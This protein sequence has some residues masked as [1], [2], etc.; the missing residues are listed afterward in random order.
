M[1]LTYAKRDDSLTPSFFF[2][3]QAVDNQRIAYLTGVSSSGKDFLLERALGEMPEA[4]RPSVL[5]MG[6][7][8]AERSSI[9][10]D[11]IRERVTADELVRS[12]MDLIEH[13]QA[14]A[15]TIFNSHMVVRHN[16]MFMINPDFELAL[17]PSH[18]V[19]VTAPPDS[20]HKWRTDR[21]QAGIRKSRIETRD[22]IMLHQLIAQRTAEIFAQFA[23]AELIIVNNVPDLTAQNVATI[24]AVL[25]NL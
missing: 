24:R 9:D 4:E 1:E 5:S 20:I 15:P 2:M 18:Y 11:S 21:N 8:L 19:L 10:R 22:D 23:R 14:A 17:R 6:T 25:T 16:G 7:L 3:E 13:I 12:Q